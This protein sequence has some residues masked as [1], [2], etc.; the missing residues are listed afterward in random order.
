M[1]KKVFLNEEADRLEEKDERFYTADGENFYPGWTTVA[2]AL[3]KPALNE[4]YKDVGHNA[5]K[6]AERAALVG[7]NVHDALE[8]VANGQNVEYPNYTIEE[9]GLILK[10]CEFLSASQYTP[11]GWE[12]MPHPWELEILAVEAKFVAP[13]LGYGGTIDLVANL[14]GKVWL[15]DWKTS[16]SVYDEY[17]LQLTAYAKAWNLSGM[18]KVERMGVLWLKSEHKGPAKNGPTAKSTGI[19]GRG[20]GLR[21]FTE[22]NNWPACQAIL[23]AFRWQNPNYK[24]RSLVYPTSI[25]FEQFDLSKRSVGVQELKS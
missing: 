6:I 8:L 1:E 17:A 12:P 20:W 22:K 23:E 13:E 19:Q 24:P 10:G 21:D 4:W 11:D 3:S 18:D 9:W 2:Q 15:L 5:D 25:Q 14:N 7:T 16:K